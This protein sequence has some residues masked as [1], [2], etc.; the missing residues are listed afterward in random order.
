MENSQGALDNNSVR[1]SVDGAANWEN[2]QMQDTELATKQLQDANG[3]VKSSESLLTVN[4][5][6]YDVAPFLDL[7]PGGPDLIAEHLNGKDVG[8]L[9]KGLDEPGAHAH[10]KAA[11]KML[12]QFLLKDL[13][14]SEKRV[15]EPQKSEKKFQVDLTKP[16]VPQ[17]GYLG[18]DYDEWVHTPIISKESPRFFESDFLESF[19]R[20]EWWTI[21]LVWGPLVLWLEIRALKLGVPLEKLLPAM[22]L[23]YGM[24]SILEYFLHRFLFHMKAHTYW[25]ATAHYLLHGFHHKHPMD[26]KRIVFPPAFATPIVYL[27]WLFVKAIFPDGFSHSVFGGVMLGY[28]VYDL[29][30]YFLHFGNGFTHQLRHMKRYHLNHH[31]KVQTEGFGVSSEVWDWVFGTL[32]ANYRSELSKKD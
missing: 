20:S 27:T 10:S 31:F 4:G 13:T 19:T 15:E 1:E 8:R 25:T 9:M 12:E 5:K 7:H 24:W 28:I 30:H 16:L 17:V 23:G 2:I 21:P 32:P 26:Y 29:T 22:L 3:G 11:M 6:V 18:K 14:L